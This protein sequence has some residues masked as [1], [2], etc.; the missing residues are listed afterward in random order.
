MSVSLLLLFSLSQFQTIHHLVK[1]IMLV[2]F[3]V[4]LTTN[5]PGE[6]SL[7]TLVSLVA[8]SV[9]VFLVA[10]HQDLLSRTE[11][12]WRERLKGEEEGVDTMQGINRVLLENLLP[13]HVARHF[14]TI[15]KVR[16]GPS[17]QVNYNPRRGSSDKRR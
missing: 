16:T 10:R 13:A 3:T 2:I 17:N 15:I 12:L 4:I 7:P 6:E 11:W 5:L 8:S 1:L 14:I 9:V